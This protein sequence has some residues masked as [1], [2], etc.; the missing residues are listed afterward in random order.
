MT[1]NIS[2]P[3]ALPAG[4]DPQAQGALAADWAYLTNVAARVQGAAWLHIVTSQKGATR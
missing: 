1:R 2:N 4:G 3:H